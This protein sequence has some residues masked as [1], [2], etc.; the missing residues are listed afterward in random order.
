MDYEHFL[1]CVHCTLLWW[2][3]NNIYD[4]EL[5]NKKILWSGQKVCKGVLA[6]EVHQVVYKMW[7]KCVQMCTSCTLQVWQPWIYSLG[8]LSS[9][10]KQFP[11]GTQAVFKLVHHLDTYVHKRVSKLRTAYF[12]AVQVFKI[13]H[14]LCY[15]PENIFM[16]Q[17]P[18]SSR[19]SRSDTLL[20]PFARINYYFHCFCT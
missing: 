15:F 10:P 4:Y 2:Y 5:V 16:V 1:Y 3:W 13:V 18:R 17:P 11:S 20:C 14:G 12:Y 9:F 19:L 8:K 6:S 7:P